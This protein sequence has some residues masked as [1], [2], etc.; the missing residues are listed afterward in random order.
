MERPE[1]KVSEDIGRNEVILEI[2][3][4]TKHVSLS[5]FNQCMRELR[6]PSMEAFFDRFAE[7]CDWFIEREQCVNFEMI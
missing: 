3:G 1:I 2:L 6:V 5:V 4:E 7:V